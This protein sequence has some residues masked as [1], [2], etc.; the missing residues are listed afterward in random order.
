VSQRRAV[1]CFGVQKNGGIF[2][3]IY[4][5]GYFYSMCFILVY[6]V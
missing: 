6:T 1:D 4:H 5:I 2:L 3:V